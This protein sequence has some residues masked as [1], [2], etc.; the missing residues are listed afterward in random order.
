M[1]NLTENTFISYTN[2]CE[3]SNLIK[4]DTYLS[5]LQCSTNLTTFQPRKLQQKSF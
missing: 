1:M 3:G 5:H 2:D 4:L